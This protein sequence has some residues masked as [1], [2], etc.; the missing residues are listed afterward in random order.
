M[1]KED[2]DATDLRILAELQRDARL[3]N[4][5]L[6]E[7]INLSPSPCL[8]RTK[9]L[10]EVGL[11]RGYRADLDR[12]KLGLGLTVF[13]EIKVARHSRSNADGLAAALTEIPEVVSCCMVSGAAD[14]LVELV[15]ADLP[16][17]ERLLSDRLLTLSMVADIRS[18]F[19]LRMIKTAGPLALPPAGAS[20]G[21]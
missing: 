12:D 20:R 19:A 16:A 5:E 7:R 13:V 9:R 10:E 14:F 6:A 17:Y 3:A 11:I 8:R 18:N 2:L 21:D 15:V 1:P 4:V